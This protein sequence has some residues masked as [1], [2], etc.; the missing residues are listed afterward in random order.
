MKLV[1]TV[2]FAALSL[3]VTAQ[4]ATVVADRVVVTRTNP[5]PLPTAF[6][7]AEVQ[8]FEQGS[9]TNVAASAA[10][11]SATASSTG[12]G[13]SPDWAIDG[14]T[15]GNFGANSSWH[16][17][18]GQAGDDPSQTDAYTVV[19]SAPRSVGSFNLWG[20][21]DGCCP[22]RDDNMRVDFFLGAA[23]V[24]QNE[25]VGIFGV[26]AAA[27]HESGVTPITAIPEPV[28]AGAGALA[29]AMAGL[30]RR[31]RT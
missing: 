7:L 2:P 5:P 1:F 31:R 3:A 6:H 14:N 27:G 19:F 12:W 26:G 9:G 29:L 30:A 22:E 17:L 4:A 11:S 25:N 13:T 28:A 10:G 18:D 8:V 16:D 20:R 23:L 21:S 24:G 15:D